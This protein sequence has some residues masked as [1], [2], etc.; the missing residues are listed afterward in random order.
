MKR[1]IHGWWSPRLEKNM[2]IVVYGHWGKP[3]LM[4]P[5]AGADFLEYERFQLI[6][7]IAPYIEAGKIKVFSINSINNE[8]W[9]NNSMAPHHKALRHMTY[10]YYVT[11]EVVP[12]IHNNCGGLQPIM[13]TGASLGALHAANIFF[14]SPHLFAGTI[15]MSGFYDL[16]S[17]T[18]G[19]YDENVYFNSPVDYLSNLGD[20]N[21]LNQ[22]R[23]GKRIIIATGQGEYEVPQGSINLSNILRS[24]GIPHELEIW[25][26]D[27]P[28]DWPTWR[29]MLPYFVSKL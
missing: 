4:F 12:F 27:M 29:K 16:K 7:A 24:K 2:E 20:E 11:D 22:M 5:T 9:L 18:K 6:D 1:E 14:R 10:N 21:L 3:L 28:H 13:L 25:G 8:S 15:P 17:Y 19:Y 26:H 23:H